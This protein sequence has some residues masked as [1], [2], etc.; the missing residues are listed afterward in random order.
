MF[1]IALWVFAAIGVLVFI[2]FVAW[3]LIWAIL[4]S[5]GYTIFEMLCVSSLRKAF[6]RP[7]RVIYFVLLACPWHGF[8]DA[9]TCPCSEYACREWRWTPLFK[10]SRRAK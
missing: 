1:D 3:P 4:Y 5:I 6:K 2:W 8:K 10:Y 7:F 9:M